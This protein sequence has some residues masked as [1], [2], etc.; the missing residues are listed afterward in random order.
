MH[1]ARAAECCVSTVLLRFIA[2][3]SQTLVGNAETKSLLFIPGWKLGRTL[4]SKCLIDIYIFIYILIIRL[5]LLTH[6]LYESVKPITC[7]VIV[8]RYSLL[9]L[10]YRAPADSIISANP[11]EGMKTQINKRS[12]AMEELTS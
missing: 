5:N 7:C 6:S 11:R 10:F 8:Q 2:E 12:T 1:R 9:L 3:E 4:L